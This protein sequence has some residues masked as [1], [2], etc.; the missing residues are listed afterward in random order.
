VG[1]KILTQPTNLDDGVHDERRAKRRVRA[2][3][4][5]TANGRP[6]TCI[7]DLGTILF[8]IKEGRY[9]IENTDYVYTKSSI[10]Y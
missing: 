3:R 9:P 6:V 1:V 8:T 7:H 4:R 2:K 10:H 5:P